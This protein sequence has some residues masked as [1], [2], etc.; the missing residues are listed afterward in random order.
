MF[1]INLIKLT[2]ILELDLPV[3]GQKNRTSL[4]L[5]FPFVLE[6]GLERSRYQ[7]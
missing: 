3:G 7:V 2:Q 1:R 6:Q 5:S 4:D